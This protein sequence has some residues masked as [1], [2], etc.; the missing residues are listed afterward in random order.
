MH[1]LGHVLKLDVDTA[2]VAYDKLYLLISGMLFSLRVTLYFRKV[3]KN[4]LSL[5]AHILVYAYYK[6][7]CI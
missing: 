3:K 5:T 6:H 2:N 1:A 7:E 4:S